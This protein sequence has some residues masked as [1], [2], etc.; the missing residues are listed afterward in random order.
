M[1]YVDPFD[2]SAHRHPV[3]DDGSKKPAK[4]AAVVK[5]VTIGP[6]LHSEIV[7]LIVLLAF[8]FFAVVGGYAAMQWRLIHNNGRIFGS[9]WLQR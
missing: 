4:P 5:R 8:M 9:V 3:Q 2:L 6:I 7:K 1:A